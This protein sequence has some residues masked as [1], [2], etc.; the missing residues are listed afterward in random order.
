MVRFIPAC[1][2]N[3][4]QHSRST[5]RSPVHPRVCGEL[6]AAFRLCRIGG[7]SSP[8]VWGTHHLHP[9]H[10]RPRRFIPACVG[11]SIPIRYRFGLG[12]V[13]PRV[14]GELRC[15]RGIRVPIYGSSPRVWGT[16]DCF[17]C[18][19]LRGRFIPACVGNSTQY[20]LQHLRHSVHPRVCGELM[21]RAQSY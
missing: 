6:D 9:I 4:R 17:Q 12:S 21:D 19:L 18:G 15:R 8:R 13:H 14:C 16:L 20:R 10:V 2:G 5:C 7:G 3:S 1:V 11:N